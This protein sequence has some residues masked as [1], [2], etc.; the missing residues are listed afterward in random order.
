MIN[1]YAK[2]L[3][4][5]TKQVK[6][7]IEAAGSYR[8]NN[9]T[10]YE[11]LVASTQKELLVP[12]LDAPTD[13]FPKDVKDFLS[14]KMKEKP[15]SQIDGDI[16]KCVA[17]G[18]NYRSPT[19]ENARTSSYAFCVSTAKRIMDC[20]ETVLK[21]HGG[22][23]FTQLLEVYFTVF[24]R[25]NTLNEHFLDNVPCIKK[26]SGF[27]LQFT[28]NTEV[29]SIDFTINDQTNIA[30]LLVSNEIAQIL[31]SNWA[32]GYLF[33]NSA[34]NVFYRLLP[35]NHNDDG[36]SKT[37]QEDWIPS[38]ARALSIHLSDDE[39]TQIRNPVGSNQKISLLEALDKARQDAQL[40]IFS[41]PRS[42]V[43]I[44]SL[45]NI[46]PGN[47]LSFT[48][49]I[50]RFLYMIQGS[51]CL[52][53]W[54][55]DEEGHPLPVIS[56]PAFN[57]PLYNSA[58]TLIP[59][60]SC[61]YPEE[62]IKLKPKIDELFSYALKPE[63]STQEDPITSWNDKKLGSDEL[64]VTLNSL[65]RNFVNLFKQ[66]Q[67]ITGRSHEGKPIN[68][69]F[70]YGPAE[71]LKY[72]ERVVSN[73]QLC[74]DDSE[75]KYPTLSIQCYGHYA[76]FQQDRFAG[77]IDQNHNLTCV[78]RMVVM[79]MPSDT[80][81]DLMYTDET[82]PIL[83]DHYRPM[84]W[85]TWKV[86]KEDKS[87]TA[88]AL[89]AGGD[90]K[91]RVFLNGSLQLIW[92]KE[93]DH[94]NKHWS[95]GIECKHSDAQASNTTKLSEAI[96]EVLGKDAPVQQLV[97]T[98][99]EISDSSG[100]GAAFII[101]GKA[102]DLPVVSDMVPDNFKMQ[103]ARIRELNGL[104]QKLLRSLAV[105][106]GVVHIASYEDNKGKKDN[107]GKRSWVCARRFISA[108]P[109][110]KDGKSLTAQI[111]LDEYI[112]TW[113]DALDSCPQKDDRGKEALKTL[114]K[115]REGLGA[116]GA[117]H[118]SVLQLCIWFLQ[119][120]KGSEW[121]LVCSISADGSVMLYK[122]RQCKCEKQTLYLWTDNIIEM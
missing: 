76:L 51:L 45:K 98:I 42:G 120:Y 13:P 21:E 41:D 57:D 115:W 55:Q 56:L 27:Y 106:D 39:L 119:K 70:I 80:E 121:P 118:R 64:A 25:G 1:N 81:Q 34:W 46:Y 92:R 103:W 79:K 102:A 87:K 85:L 11:A 72:I 52:V 48:Q 12:L 50:E 113:I 82:E 74:S 24:G 32:L 100:E 63:K 91:L 23:F 94:E 104:E 83:N 73:E 109:E 36:F 62:W 99:W 5:A 18:V 90:G 26:C 60:K 101:G 43:W 44:A 61:I 4:L 105:M 35:E 114:E 107:E 69:S 122:I 28:D 77:F 8:S 65:G 6:H 33:W 108:D 111:I 59:S 17:V 93:T 97:S 89:V 96:E 14:G 20:N 40:K 2:W 66:I 75:R 15:L 84:R 117:R 16:P 31:T 58:W 22:Q 49:K 19:V 3:N 112:E 78:N 7:W 9:P 38:A 10:L 29:G 47:E 88:V 95:L 68:F 54:A 71:T 116:R 67:R 53:P 30:T 110:A 86:H 37:L